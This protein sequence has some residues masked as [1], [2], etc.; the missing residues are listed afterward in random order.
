MNW[1]QNTL[2]LS[3]LD[4]N[5]IKKGNGENEKEMAFHLNKWTMAIK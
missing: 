2:I 4:I 3:K 1:S 5:H